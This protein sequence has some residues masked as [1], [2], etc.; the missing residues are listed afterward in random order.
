MRQFVLL[1]DMKQMGVFSVFIFAHE[2]ELN[3]FLIQF[4]EHLYFSKAVYC[5]FLRKLDEG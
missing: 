4:V 2:N 1:F 3:A 5:F